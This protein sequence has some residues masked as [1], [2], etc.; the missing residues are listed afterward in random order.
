M[1]LNIYIFTI[2]TLIFAVSK[3]NICFYK[4]IYGDFSS[5]KYY[6]FEIYIIQEKYFTAF[7]I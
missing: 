3:L 5:L 6:I 7:F 1:I 4:T 2:L